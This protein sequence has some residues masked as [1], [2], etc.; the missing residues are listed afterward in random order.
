MAT[1]AIVAAAVIAAAAA[2]YLISLRIR[3]WWPCRACEGSGKTRDR[4]WK[5]AI[6]TCPKCGGRGRQPRL[7]VRILTP[8]RHKRLT[9]GRA[10]AQE[11]RPEEALMARGTWQ[12]GGT[13]QTQTGGG[14]GPVLIVVI[15]A[16]A[17]IGSGAASAAV[18][19]LEVIAIVIACRRGRRARRHRAARVPGALGGAQCQDG[20]SRPGRCTSYPVRAAPGMSSEHKP[21]IEP[22]REIHL[23]FH[24]T[25]PAEAAEIIRQA[26][27]G[28][29]GDAITEGK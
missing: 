4:I 29:A 12:G 14:G 10:E 28:T 13:W 17:A 23:H 11:H 20:R 3:P 25:D 1:L 2:A 26:L 6:G 5:Q 15:V 21:A 22:P 24:V 7:G 19:A 8:G 18:S 16:A 9:A 27:P